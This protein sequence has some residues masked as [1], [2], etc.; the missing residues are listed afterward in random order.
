MMLYE[1][2]HI[3]DLYT[4]H[5]RITEMR[6]FG[7]N[8]KIGNNKPRLNRLN[9]LIFTEDFLSYSLLLQHLANREKYFRLKAAHQLLQQSTPS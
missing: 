9:K 7:S 8:A 1:R 6:E 3:Y 4:K 2:D 5:I